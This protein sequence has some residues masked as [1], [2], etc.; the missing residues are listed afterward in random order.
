MIYVENV[1]CDST[2]KIIV[3]MLFKCITIVWE[4]EKNEKLL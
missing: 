2:T 1:G 4:E 3:N